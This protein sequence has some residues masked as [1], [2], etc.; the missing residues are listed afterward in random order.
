MKQMQLHPRNRTD[1]CPK[2]KG[3]GEYV[4]N[5]D[6]AGTIH[7]DGSYSGYRWRDCEDCYGLGIVS[8]ADF[9]EQFEEIGDE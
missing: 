3:E 7:R 9:A 4:F 6:T 5:P 8:A 2:C 1:R